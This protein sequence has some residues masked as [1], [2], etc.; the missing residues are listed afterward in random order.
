MA[1]DV[2]TG[3]LAVELVPG[4]ILHVPAWHDDADGLDEDIVRDEVDVA[5]EGEHDDVDEIAII[6]VFFKVFST[7]FNQD[8]DNNNQHRSAF[9]NTISLL[10]WNILFI[11]F[12]WNDR[13][14]Y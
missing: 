2:M 14:I 3:T 10:L 6:A 8:I 7:S 13:L 9:E 1:K 4:T 12:F 11:M 5:G